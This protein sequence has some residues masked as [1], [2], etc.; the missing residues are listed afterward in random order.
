MELLFVLLVLLVVTRAFGECAERLGQPVLAGEL[1]AGI[2][3]GLLASAFSGVFPVLATLAD[4]E[5][6]RAIT[7]LGIFFLMLQAGLELRPRD[8]ARASGTAVVVAAAGLVVPLG[9]GF[10]LGWLAM[11]ESD[12]RLAQALFLGVALAITAVPVSVRVLMDIGK[13]DTPVGRTIVS[14]AV[15]DDVFSLALLAVLTA[16][17]RS[18]TVPGAGELLLIGGK[19][20]LFFVAVYAVGKILPRLG[21]LV[22]RSRLEEL[23]FS[24][25]VVLAL[26]L[27]VLAEHLGLHFIIGAFAAG[28]AFGRETI[29]KEVYGQVQERISGLSTGFL[30]PIFFASIGL[31]TDLGSLG[32][33]PLFVLGVLLVASFGKIVGS[34]VPA[35]ALGM[36]TREALAVGVAMNARGAVELIVAGVALRAGLF[37][38]PEPPP[39]IVKH[40]FS[41]VVVMA[42]VTTVATPVILGRLLPRSR[43]GQ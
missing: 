24:F 11:P 18:G 20:L 12:A 10:L 19:I 15:Y 14:A 5:V 17:I 13:L 2:L 8:L 31:H 27:A 32:A 16:L 22:R 34:A 42:I 26:G 25:V 39:P 6:F 28:L 23:E 3:I 36:E 7:D 41:T 21:R 9:S 38:R 29:D 30:A 40:L 43:K 35:K 4:D 1:V 33:V 37:S